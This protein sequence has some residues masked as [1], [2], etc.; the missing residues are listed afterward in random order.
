LN[1]ASG[2][3]LISSFRKG[4]RCEK[5]ACYGDHEDET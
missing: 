3:I 1:H 5:Y 4:Q 2:Y